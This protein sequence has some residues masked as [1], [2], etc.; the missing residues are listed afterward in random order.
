N[1][2]SIKKINR[3]Q[4]EQLLLK[5]GQDYGIQLQLEKLYR[6]PANSTLAII[7]ELAPHLRANIVFHQDTHHDNERMMIKGPV[8]ILYPQN[9]TYP[10]PLY[11]KPSLKK[12]KDSERI[13]R[14]D[15]KIDPE[16][17]LPALRAHRYLT[18]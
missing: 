16:P 8:P 5:K 10:V 6:L 15:M 7:Q 2:R 14:N 18:D 17:Y 4:A 1:T 9:E 3:H 11:T 12:T 13:T